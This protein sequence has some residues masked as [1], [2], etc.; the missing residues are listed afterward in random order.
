MAGVMDTPALPARTAE[1]DT[2]RRLFDAQRTAFAREAYP[3]IAVRRDR[4]DRLASL[5]DKHEGEIVRAIAADFGSR[6]A[7]ETR[8]T[9]LFMVRAGI[10][11][12]RRHLA[13]WMRPRR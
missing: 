6:P 3:S 8:V 1:S 10:R 2:L 12:A 9:E 13:R 5:T 11:Y 4:L 7:Q